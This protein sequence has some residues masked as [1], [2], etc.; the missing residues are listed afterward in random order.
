MHLGL[1]GIAG[2][3]FAGV[4]A[5]AGVGALSSCSCGPD[6]AVGDRMPTHPHE[7]CGPANE[8]DDQAQPRAELSL[9]GRSRLAAQEIALHERGVRP[10]ARP[11][12]RRRHTGHRSF[13]IHGPH[14]PHRLMNRLVLTGT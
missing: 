8:L 13:G 1:A 12:C 3:G 4:Q 5:A 6:A 9:Q 14:A 7:G 11:A 2:E 10:A